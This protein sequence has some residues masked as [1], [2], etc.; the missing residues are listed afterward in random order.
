MARDPE[1][2]QDNGSRQD[3][4]DR[5]NS[6]MRDRKLPCDTGQDDVVFAGVA[7]GRDN[8]GVNPGG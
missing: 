8:T 4:Q 2:F 5:I 6:R 1:H 7:S 3:D